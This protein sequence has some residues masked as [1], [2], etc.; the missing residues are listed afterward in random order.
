MA[1]REAATTDPLDPRFLEGGWLMS[2]H[3][4]KFIIF[5]GEV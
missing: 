3:H 4:S 2:I 5:E 1:F